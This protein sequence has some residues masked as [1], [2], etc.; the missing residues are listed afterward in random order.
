MDAI[1][2]I[3]WKIIKIQL[4]IKVDSFP[5]A[6]T[7]KPLSNTDHMS[8]TD[9]SNQQLETSN[10]NILKQKSIYDRKLK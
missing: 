8:N 6:K 2:F 4:T 7:V 10:A 9:R 5:Q 1:E 3:H